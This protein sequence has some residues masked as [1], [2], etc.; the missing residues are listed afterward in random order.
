MLSASG[1][2]ESMEIS[3]EAK[4]PEQPPGKLKRAFK[5]ILDLDT[6]RL[7]AVASLLVINCFVFTILFTSG[8]GRDLLKFLEDAGGALSLLAAMAAYLVFLLSIASI[9]A[10]GALTE[11]EEIKHPIGKVF[12]YVHIGALITFTLFAIIVTFQSCS[13]GVVACGFK[14]YAVAIGVIVITVISMILLVAPLRGAAQAS[15]IGGAIV[16]WIIGASVLL[17]TALMPGQLGHFFG[18]PILLVVVM[19]AWVYVF[20]GL[21]LV[22][23][24]GGRQGKGP[25]IA[26]LLLLLL[27]L[28]KSIG[29]GIL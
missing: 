24:V 25:R 1:L 26:V 2:N 8:Q 28:G 17:V 3:P 22:G 19:A 18:S 4:A 21:A 7:M 23:S 6:G 12:L 20:F 10:T 15:S 5:F 13:Y 29:V 16:C 27:L 9:I 11:E 14:S